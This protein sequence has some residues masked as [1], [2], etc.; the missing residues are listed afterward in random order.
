MVKKLPDAN[1]K[2]G[3]FLAI[4][5][6][7]TAF[8]AFISV[9]TAGGA[10][11][12]WDIPTERVDGTPVELSGF[13]VY[14]TTV[15]GGLLQ[16]HSEISIPDATQ[17]EFTDLQLGEHFFAV[18]AV[19]TNGLASD[20]S[21]IA[22]KVITADSPPGA[23]VLTPTTVELQYI[24]TGG[25]MYYVQAGG[26]VIS[27]HSTLYKALQTA[28][29]YKAANLQAVVAVVQTLEIRVEEK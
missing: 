8:F 27:S 23:P 26:A 7:I 29:Q 28:H 14:H 13:R 5:F 2:L 11:L 10:L 17:Y 6:L 4:L 24:S 12:S 20:F 19:D 15:K 9:A 25:S 1:G 22:S 16:L 21:N 18:K 3:L